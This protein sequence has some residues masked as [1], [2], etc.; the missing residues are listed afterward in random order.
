MEELRFPS[1]ADVKDQDG[2]VQDERVTFYPKLVS[3]NA[4]VPTNSE[5]KRR[6]IY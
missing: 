2:K 6:Y 5:K 3:K 4:E 1:A